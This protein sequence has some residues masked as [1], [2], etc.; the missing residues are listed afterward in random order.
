MI[1][2]LLLLGVSLFALPLHALE[3]TVG[4]GLVTDVSVNPDGFL[5]IRTD[6]DTSTLTC[7]TVAPDGSFWWLRE[8]NGQFYRDVL[9]MAMTA[10]AAGKEV[11]VKTADLDPGDNSSLCVEGALP[12]LLLSVEEP[13]VP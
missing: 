8:Y 6:I 3:L 2:A 9:A 7:P 1:R 11:S 4:P 10:M 5:V 13:I 12:I